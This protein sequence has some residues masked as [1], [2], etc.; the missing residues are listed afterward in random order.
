MTPLQRKIYNINKLKN[1]NQNMKNSL[2]RRL[3]NHSTW[4]T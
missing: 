4:H 1:M 3:N 2:N